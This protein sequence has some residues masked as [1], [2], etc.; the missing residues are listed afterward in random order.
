[1]LD[2]E[3]V[4]LEV[5]MELINK[6]LG[7]IVVGDDQ[8][9]KLDFFVSAERKGA[10]KVDKLNIMDGFGDLADFDPMDGLDDMNE[11]DSDNMVIMGIRAK[12]NNI[13]GFDIMAES[14]LD[15]FEDMDVSD[16]M[17]VS[18]CGSDTTEESDDDE[19]SAGHPSTHRKV[20]G[21]DEINELINDLEADGIEAQEEITSLIV[22]FDTIDLRE[23]SPRGDKIAELLQLTPKVCDL[24]LKFSCYLDSPDNCFGEKLM[25][26]LCSLD[27]ET[28]AHRA[29]NPTLP[30]NLRLGRNKSPRTDFGQ[31][32]LLKLV[33][34]WPNLHTLHIEGDT[35]GPPYGEELPPVTCAIRFVTF[36]N[37]TGNYGFISRIFA[38]SA[39]SLVGFEAWTL[40]ID[41]H[42]Q[43][44]DPLL[45]PILPSIQSLDISGYNHPSDRFLRHELPS[46]HHLCNLR[47]RGHN[48][49]L[50]KVMR[51]M[52]QKLMKTR[53]WRRTSLRKIM[54]H[55]HKKRKLKSQIKT[56]QRQLL[57][58]KDADGIN[59][60]ELLIKNKL[61]K[62]QRKLLAWE[63]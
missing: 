51:A 57:N 53:E 9:M 20:T 14:D 47:L 8:Q 34:Y 33:A 11:Y 60:Q 58:Y 31:R 42:F 55:K 63:D 41:E 24:T 29:M 61:Q 4:Q 16:R 19:S 39:Q 28:F 1:M 40:S 54:S 7:E 2:I 44:L 52:F 37:L 56:F 46:A 5:L 35:N 49:R 6:A 22:F 26:A 30:T 45:R 13:A 23:K 12:Y 50:N 36:E 62:K 10:N 25:S 43:P 15:E 38:G 32:N 59:T 17:E 3:R 18:E 21:M 48:K 27:I